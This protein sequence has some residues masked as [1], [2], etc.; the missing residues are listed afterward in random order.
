VY[1]AYFGNAMIGVRAPMLPSGARLAAAG[2]VLERARTFSDLPPGV[3]FW[4]EN[5]NGLA[6]IAVNLGRADRDLGL[7]VGSPVEIIS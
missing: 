3:A 2:R 5:S 6:E 7:T 1:V 4:Y